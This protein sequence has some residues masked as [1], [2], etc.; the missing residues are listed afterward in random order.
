MNTELLKPSNKINVPLEF[1]YTYG[2]YLNDVYSEEGQFT[3]RRKKDITLKQ[4]FS[5]KSTTKSSEV[6]EEKDEEEE[7]KKELPHRNEAYISRDKNINNR[8]WLKVPSM[9]RTSEQKERI[10]G[11]RSLWNA[12][13]NR[14]LMFAVHLETINGETGELEILDFTFVFDLLVESRNPLPISLNNE[15]RSLLANVINEQGKGHVFN[16]YDITFNQLIEADNKYRLTVST[17]SDTK[18]FQFY[19]MNDDTVNVFNHFDKDGNPV[20]ETELASSYEFYDVWDREFVMVTSSIATNTT[21]NQI[22]FTGVRYQPIKY[23][24]LQSNQT[25]FW[26]DLWLSHYMKV[27]CN[28]PRDGKDGFTMEVILLDNDNQLYT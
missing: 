19:Y 10:I 17:T 20:R 9:W 13:N 26:V 1:F 14:Q 23:F 5:H 24:R 12:E 11:I 2:S 27:P 8:Y 16:V 3:S 28:L 4:L 21:K 15:M 25:T 6:V 22:G 7:D 18:Y